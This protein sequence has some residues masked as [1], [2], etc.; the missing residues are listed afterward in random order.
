MNRFTWPRWIGCLSL[1]LAIAA[2]V[3]LHQRFQ[4]A[5]THYAHITGWVLFATM[6]LLTAYNGRKK[7]PFLPLGS[8]ESWLQIHLYAGWFTV[9][10]F[11]IH[12]K[13]RMPTGWFECTLIWLY[14]LVT[15]SGVVGLIISRKLP[16]RLAVRKGEVLYE[17]IPALRAALR[18]EA[19]T[20]VLGPQ[21]KS[22][23][24]AEFYERV[25][26]E[27]FSGPKNFWLHLFESRRP[28]HGVMTEI[29]ELHR[30]LNEAERAALQPLKELVRQK[31][32]LDYHYAL[33]TA[34]KLWLFVH[35][36]LTY[37][38][39]IFSL[40]HIVVVF[41]FSGGAR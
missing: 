3:T 9:V 32:S 5:F 41:A 21:A 16:K 22:S 25:L 19:E 30:Y 20:L 11:L 8:S 6:V 15:G 34:L 27:F 14:L 40:L 12:L 18:E 13:F 36:P 31:D 23:A 4:N 2:A 39:M 1:A 29:E 26:A 35:L 24:I 33:Q 10:L 7:L 28:L 38:L 37:S 17:S